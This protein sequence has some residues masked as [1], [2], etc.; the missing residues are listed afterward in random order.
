M[1]A[2]TTGDCAH[3]H[4]LVGTTVTRCTECGLA[5]A[6]YETV[7]DA[8]A[9]CRAALDTPERNVAGDTDEENRPT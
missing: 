7:A 1:T 5:V 6:R 2:T 3:E 9:A 4:W 8:I